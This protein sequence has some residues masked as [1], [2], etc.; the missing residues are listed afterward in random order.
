MR[1]HVWGI[2]YS[3]IEWYNL[4]NSS[5][6]NLRILCDLLNLIIKTDIR[7]TIKKMLFLMDCIKLQ[8]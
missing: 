3:G 8:K 7:N 2:Y 4:C 6:I 1:V 5:L